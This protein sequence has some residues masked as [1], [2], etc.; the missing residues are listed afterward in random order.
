MTGFRILS[1]FF[2]PVLLVQL[3]CPIILSQEPVKLRSTLSISGSSGTIAV[4]GK[5]YFVQQITGQSGIIGLSDA[6]TYRL[7]Q[8]FIQPHRG[9]KKIIESEYLQVTV[10]PNPFPTEI[11]ISFTETIADDLYVS[12]C[13]LNG[14]SVYFNKYPAIQEISLNF[15]SLPPALYILRVY[16]DTKYYI[17]KLIK[18]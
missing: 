18:E 3:S 9:F 15:G 13:D 10:S 4:R 6:S 7:R 11:R 5:Q 12:L 8:G 14:K 2:L 16:T 17:S 1:K